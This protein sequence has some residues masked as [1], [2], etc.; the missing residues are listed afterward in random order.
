MNL[1]EKYCLKTQLEL[2][3]LLEENFN[4]KINYKTG[5]A[6][7]GDQKFYVSDITKISKEFSWN[8]EIDYKK[9]IL[10]MY[11]SQKVL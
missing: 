10:E 7:P 9:G 11:E 2:F 6:R 4:V 1:P 5:L 8:P 3:N